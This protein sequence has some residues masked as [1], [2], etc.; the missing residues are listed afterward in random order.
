MF[1]F[2][3]QAFH[4]SLT[5]SFQAF[6]SSFFTCKLTAKLISNQGDDVHN[7][8]LSEDSDHCSDFSG[9]IS[10]VGLARHLLKA[11]LYP[12]LLV[13]CHY[14]SYKNLQKPSLSNRD[15]FA[16]EKAGYMTSTMSVYL[17]QKTYL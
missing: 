17:A 13:V 2:I 3:Q 15:P 9:L 12:F 16:R 11:I 5:N 6:N 7:E 14:S 8:T 4:Q 10:A 1:S